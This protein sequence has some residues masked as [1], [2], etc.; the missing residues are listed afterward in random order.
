MQTAHVARR[1]LFRANIIAELVPCLHANTS[2]ISTSNF[3]AIGSRLYH[4]CMLH[5][6]KRTGPQHLQKRLGS[7]E[8][9]KL[10]EI[11]NIQGAQQ[12]Q[13]Y[14]TGGITKW[15]PTLVLVARFSVHVQHYE[16]LPCDSQHQ[17]RR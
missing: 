6:A 16:S 12:E 5:E 3:T 11:Q 15:S 13:K 9:K 14:T 8:S 2:R 17:H 10:S 4:A 1:F 7:S